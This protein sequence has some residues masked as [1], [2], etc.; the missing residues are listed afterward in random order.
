MLRV[1]NLLY[2]FDFQVVNSSSSKLETCLKFL[3]LSEDFR[4]YRNCVL[5][6]YKHI[7][8]TLEMKFSQFKIQFIQ[9]K[10]IKEF[11]KKNYPNKYQK[12]KECFIHLKKFCQEPLDRVII[13]FIVSSM[14]NEFV[15]FDNLDVGDLNNKNFLFEDLQNI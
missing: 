4:Y 3:R 13:F 1:F 11:V 6:I 5:Y 9:Y 2:N 12:L 8:N 14:I 10:S 7:L 15:F